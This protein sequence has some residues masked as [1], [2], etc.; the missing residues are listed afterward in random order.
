ML[1]P[2]ILWVP[3]PVILGDINPNFTGLL[4][5][6]SQPEKPD[7]ISLLQDVPEVIRKRVR[8]AVND[9]HAK[10]CKRVQALDS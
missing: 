1:T 4:F 3:E 6:D 8:I 10:N 5:P 2:N 9:S 7:M